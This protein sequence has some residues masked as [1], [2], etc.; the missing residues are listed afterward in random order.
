[1]EFP[2]GTIIAWIIAPTNNSTSPETIPSGW[3]QCDGRRI[4]EG[5]WEGQLSPNL[6]N[7]H[8]FLRGGLEEEQLEIEDDMILDHVHV[9]GGH[10]H[11]QE[12]HYHTYPK[13]T[14]EYH[15]TKLD[16][17]SHCCTHRTVI[18]TITQTSNDELVSNAIP[19]ISLEMSGVGK[20]DDNFK[21]GDETRP[22][23]MKVTFLIRTS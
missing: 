17:D 7:D 18:Q 19:E 11:T 5:P 3:T 20:I 13:Y 23:N 12:A 21:K 1:M 9:D 22:K 8:L 6:N 15:T 10:K 14:D 16:Y 2:L 4:T